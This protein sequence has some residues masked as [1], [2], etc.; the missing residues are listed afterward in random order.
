MKDSGKLKLIGNERVKRQLASLVKEQALAGP[1]LFSGPEGVGKS[2]FATFFAA[3]ILKSLGDHPDLHRY[4]VEGK[5]GMHSIASM[6]TM[7]KEFYFHSY[8]GGWKVF[9]I[10]D[11][12]RMLPT[13]SNALLKSFEEPPKDTCIVLLSSHPELLLPT[14]VSRCRKIHFAP[15]EEGLIAEYLKDNGYSDY[16]KLAAASQGS[17]SKALRKNDEL[18]EHFLKLFFQKNSYLDLQSCL[19]AIE[20]E[21]EKERKQLEA[22]LKAEILAETAIEKAAFEKEIEGASFLRFYSRAS[23]ILDQALLFYRDQTLLDV[24]GP[25]KNLYFQKSLQYRIQNCPSLSH[26][27]D[28]ID[29]AKLCLQRSMKLSV[30]FENFLLSLPNF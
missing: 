23:S 26:V 9:V 21:M 3:K 22:K 2:L 19:Q 13:S 1:L 5:T 8:E 17:L 7:V 29:H 18:E 27:Q 15:I 4:K 20:T 28:L 16:Q 14:I 10:E 11:A 24:G 12:E 6:R 30:C 25:E